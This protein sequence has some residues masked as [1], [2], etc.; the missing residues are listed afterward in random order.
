MRNN[1]K[2]GSLGVR[3]RDGSVY[4]LNDRKHG[5]DRLLG[6]VA[7]AHAEVHVVGE[8]EVKVTELM[9]ISLSKVGEHIQKGTVWYTV[10]TVP[11]HSPQRNGNIDSHLAGSYKAAIPGARKFNELAGTTPAAAWL[12]PVVF[13]PPGR[14]GVPATLRRDPRT[15]HLAPV[16]QHQ[17]TAAEIFRGAKPGGITLGWESDRDTPLNRLLGRGGER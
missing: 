14:P 5:G 9:A 13:D 7:G 3:V 2:F 1:M 11:G 6:P 17:P 15:G 12:D 4:Q 8:Y 16:G 10:V